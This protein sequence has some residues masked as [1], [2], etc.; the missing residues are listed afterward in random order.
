MFT[1]KHC[2]MQ[3]S[4]VLAG[5]NK[6]KP[7]SLLQKFSYCLKCLHA[8]PVSETGSRECSVSQVLTK[9]LVFQSTHF[10]KISPTCICNAALPPSP[11]VQG[12]AFS[13]PATLSHKATGRSY[14]EDVVR[15]GAGPPL[16]L[17]TRLSDLMK[18]I[19]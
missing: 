2:S 11:E 6:A 13:H 1:G 4:K 10:G 9:E 18:R 14:P 5:L 12:G 16:G 3:L 8:S 7:V 19:S 17:S 15:H